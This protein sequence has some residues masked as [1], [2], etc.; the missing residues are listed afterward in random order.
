MKAFTIFL[1]NEIIEHRSMSRDSQVCH[2]SNLLI[3]HRSEVDE[4]C[5]YLSLRLQKPVGT[6]QFL[7]LS[8]HR[9]SLTLPIPTFYLSS[10]NSLLSTA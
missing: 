6:A 1:S 5:Y 8:W 2:A 10:D 7:R 4:R 9:F 3:V